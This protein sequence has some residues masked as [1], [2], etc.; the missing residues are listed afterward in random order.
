MWQRARPQLGAAAAV[1]ARVRLAVLEPGSFQELWDLVEA[2][3]HKL[4]A[5]TLPWD[6]SPSSP[7]TAE[8]QG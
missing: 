4:W 8:P 1:S 3:G 2:P 7:V 5:I 6:G